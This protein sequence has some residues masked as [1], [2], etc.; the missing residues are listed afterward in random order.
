MHIINELDAGGAERVLTRIACHNAR[1]SDPDAPRQIVVSLM[2]E[3]VYGPDLIEAGVELHCLGMTS[4][5]RDLPAAIFRLS[6]L[7][8]REKPDAIMSWLYHSDFIATLAALL[9]GRGTRRL[10][11][12]IRCAEMDLAQYGRSTR[13][14]L[15]LLAKLSGR[16]AIIAANSHAGQRHHISCGYHP[17][18]WAYLPN[19]FD[20]DEWHPDPGAKYRLCKQIG[21]TPDKYL[22]GM[23]A[24]KDPAKDHT[25]LFEAIRLVRAQGHHAHLVLIGHETDTLIIPDELDGHVAALGLRRDVAAL[26]PGFDIA[27]LSSSFG[28]GFPNVIGEA[29]ACGVPA[30]GNDVGDVAD[31]LGGTGKTVPLH[32]PDKLANAIVELLTEDVDSRNYRK[33]AARM[34]IIDHYSLRAMNDRYLA[35]WD[36]LAGKRD[37]PDFDFP[38]TDRSK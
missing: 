29:M 1:N 26:V 12:N 13:I 30:I 9:S 24:R 38:G 18:K 35:L 8:R 11:W 21:I 37:L 33:T 15:G 19:G 10:A 22:I 16:P 3:G 23:V 31:I 17:R 20:T 32:A 6:R 28:E 7:M 27:V 4:G 2:D 36:G 34:R 14:V 25:T 5:I